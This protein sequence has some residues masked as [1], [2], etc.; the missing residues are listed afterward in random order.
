M[1]LDG[2]F[3]GLSNVIWIRSAAE[4]NGNRVLTGSDV[5]HWRWSSKKG[6][7]FGKIADTKRSGHDD[8]SKRLQSR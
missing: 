3:D 8:E 4:V 7:I 5:D 6:F 2:L 1:D